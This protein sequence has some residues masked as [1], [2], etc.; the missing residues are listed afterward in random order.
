MLPPDD[1]HTAANVQTGLLSQEP[2]EGRIIHLRCMFGKEDGGHTYNAVRPPLFHE[3][4]DFA[5][6]HIF[7]VYDFGVGLDGSFEET[8][9]IFIYWSHPPI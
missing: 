2:L 4:R 8:F 3:Q 5:D 1:G 9:V 7:C 6:T